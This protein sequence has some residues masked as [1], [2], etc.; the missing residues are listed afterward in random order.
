MEIHEPN[1][2]K[3]CKYVQALFIEGATLELLD[4]RLVGRFT[5]KI[6]GCNMHIF[7]VEDDWIWMEEP[8]Y[9]LK[10]TLNH[11]LVISGSLTIKYNGLIGNILQLS[12][13]EKGYAQVSDLLD[14]MKVLSL[15]SASDSNIIIDS[16]HTKVRLLSLKTKGGRISHNVNYEKVFS[17]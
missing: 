6:E 5:F 12:V 10:S 11:I 14:E 13:T 15:F 2:S 9:L 16:P 1:P 17:E 7:P 4:N 3:C 8:V